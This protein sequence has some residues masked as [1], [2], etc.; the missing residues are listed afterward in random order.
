MYYPKVTLLSHPTK[1]G[2]KGLGQFLIVCNMDSKTYFTA[3]EKFEERFSED[4]I[5][6][7]KEF[8]T[9]PKAMADFWEKVANY[10]HS[11]VKFNKNTAPMMADPAVE[12]LII[13]LIK[14]IQRLTKE[15]LS[16]EQN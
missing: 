16:N 11:L 6:D 9:L 2:P 14:E 7:I 10:P 12:Q 5:T 4:R 3:W 8:D 1:E 15:A 13:V